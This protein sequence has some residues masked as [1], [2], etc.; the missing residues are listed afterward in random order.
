MLYVFANTKVIKAFG[1][2]FT[3]LN[4]YI[5]L[6]FGFTNVGGNNPFYGQTSGPRPPKFLQADPK[7]AAEVFLGNA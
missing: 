7:L 5:N 6:S 3:E 4:L 1:Q 2:Y